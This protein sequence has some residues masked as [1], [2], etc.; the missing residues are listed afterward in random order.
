MQR[1]E[2]A[3]PS[4]NSHSKTISLLV[5]AMME[6]ITTTKPILGKRTDEMEIDISC[7]PQ[8]E[9]LQEHQLHDK[10]TR[11]AESDAPSYDYDIHR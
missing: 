1:L 6:Q 10:L 5:D 2:S 9:K 7:R 3:I 4:C 8:L 11:I